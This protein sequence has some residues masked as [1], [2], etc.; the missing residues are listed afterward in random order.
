LVLAP[1]GFTGTDRLERPVSFDGVTFP[2]GVPTEATYRFDTYRLTY[3][4]R[5]VCRP[6]WNLRVGATVL[7]RDAEIGLDQGVRQA[8]KTDLGVVPLLHLD[9]EVRLAPRWRLVFDADGLA[10]EQGRAFDVALKVH[11]DLTD[12]WNVGVGYRTIE[13]GADNDEVYTFAWIHQAVLSVG[14]RF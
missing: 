13:G 12:R 14:Y 4:Y 1:L 2:A 3:R 8:T 5:L 9:A 7:L 10:A 6:R 11:Y